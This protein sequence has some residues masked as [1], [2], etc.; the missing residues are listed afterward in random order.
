MPVLVDDERDAV[1][2]GMLLRWGVQT[3]VLYRSVTEL[4]AYAAFGSCPRAED[5]AARELT[6][7]LYP[8]LSEADMDLVVEALAAEVDE[9]RSAAA[10]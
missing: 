3:S 6:L 9:S 10:A 8:H 2:A 1:R 4:T 5:V 7:P